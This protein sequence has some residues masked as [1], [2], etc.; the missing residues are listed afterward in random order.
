[1]DAGHARREA[2]PH[3]LGR[4]RRGDLA[5][6][7]GR[8]VGDRLVRSRGSIRA[9]SG[10]L[11][12]PGPTAFVLICFAPTESFGQVH[13]GVGGATQGDEQ[14][15]GGQVMALQVVEEAPTAAS[16][17]EERARKQAPGAE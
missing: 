10:A 12:S 17:R 3:G 9:L 5:A 13:R 14:H 2:R 16:L 6:A 7:T 1:M 8:E 15:Q 11:S 4:A